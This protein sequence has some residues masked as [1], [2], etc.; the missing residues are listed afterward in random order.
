MSSDDADGLPF[1]EKRKKLCREKEKERRQEMRVALSTLSKLV[2]DDQK[3]II[4]G[5]LCADLYNRTRR[6]GPFLLQL[7]DVFMN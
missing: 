5:G 3:V 6:K 4:T 2:L 7:I 1:S